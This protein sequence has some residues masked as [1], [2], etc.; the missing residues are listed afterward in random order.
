M[1]QTCHKHLVT[2]PV[3]HGLHHLVGGVVLDHLLVAALL[4]EPV[5]LDGGE[6]V[7]VHVGD[8]PAVREE[9]AAHLDWLDRAGAVN[10][11]YRL[12]VSEKRK[13]V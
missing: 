13:S 5:H 12:L 11:N 7:V 4:L 10:I 2:V 9:L 1:H 8:V 3:N 6:A